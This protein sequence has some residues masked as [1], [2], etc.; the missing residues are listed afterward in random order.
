LQARF[1]KK[2]YLY[3]QG[4]ADLNLFKNVLETKMAPKKVNSMNM[5]M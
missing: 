2:I 3:V 1:V 4:F 5:I